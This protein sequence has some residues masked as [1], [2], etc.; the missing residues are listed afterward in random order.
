MT[1]ST[2]LRALL[3]LALVALLLPGCATPRLLEAARL[4]ESPTQYRSAW[5][6]GER[7]W[8]VYDAQTLDSEGAHLGN[9]TRAARF[10]LASLDP[11][12]GYAI[13]TFPLERLDVDALELRGLEPVAL[14]MGETPVAADRSLVVEIADGRHDLLL[15]NSFEGLPAGAEFHSGA[16]T[17]RHTAAWAYPV[18]P[19]ALAYDAVA[20]CVLVPLAVPFLVAGD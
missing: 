17:D 16:L 15:A 2:E 1:R 8:L 6:D 12:R 20:A 13:D 9:R 14:H 19:F 11:A 5:T 4:T 7:L 10:E 3:L 18:L